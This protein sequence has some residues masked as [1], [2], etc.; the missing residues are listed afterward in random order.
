MELAGCHG[1]SQQITLDLC[2]VNK[3]HRVGGEL[4]RTGGERELAILARQQLCR[5]VFSS[6]PLGDR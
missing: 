4:S 6:A 3:L 1:D 5:S 2:F